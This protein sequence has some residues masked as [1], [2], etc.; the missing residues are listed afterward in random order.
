MP[1]LGLYKGDKNMNKQLSIYTILTVSTLLFTACGSDSSTPKTTI[2][3]NNSKEHFVNIT[4]TGGDT[5]DIE[6]KGSSH[7]FSQPAANLQGELF[8]YHMLGDTNFETNPNGLGPVFNHTSCDACHQKDGRDSLP[9]LLG[10]KEN[11]SNF[12]VKD[13]NGWHKLNDEGTFLRISIENDAINSAK[14]SEAN[15][16]GAPVPVP[17]F[18]D[19]LFHRGVIGVREGA[20]NEG[21]GQADV[22]MK[23]GFKDVTYPDGTKVKLSYPILAVDNPYDAPDTPNVYNPIKVETNAT[24]RLFK[25]DVRMSIRIG[26]PMIGLGLL[27]AIPKEQILALADVNDSDGNGISGKPNWVCD[28]EKYDKCKAAGNCEQNPPIS[29]GRFGWKANT[30]TVAH[31]GLGAMRGDMGVTNPLFKGESTNGTDLMNAYKTKT[32]LTT[33]EDAGQTDVDEEFAK[34][35]VFYSETLSVPPRRNIDDPEIKKGGMLFEKTGC[36]KCHNPSFTTALEYRSFSVNGKRI[37]EL[38]NQKI[39]PFSDM[40]LHDMGDGLADGRKD[41][42]ASGREWKTRPLWGIGATQT[43]NPG[44]GFLHDGRAKTLEEAILWHDGEALGVKTKFMELPKKDRE[45]II[46][47]LESL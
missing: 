22:W 44:A 6:F 26:M 8:N 13:S 30:P 46:K 7:A 14:K 23:Y 29:L 17:N 31:Q 43:I 9:V 25:P 36:V 42:D 40:L 4:R 3:I 32:G 1:F 41:F 18:S 21:A 19:Q 28:K 2:D 5:S 37:K 20:G 39:Y 33:F 34:S 10:D 45:A 11:L 27:N 47:F 35:I 16:W 24:S 15:C 12:I 38:E